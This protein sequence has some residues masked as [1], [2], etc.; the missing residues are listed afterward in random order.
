MELIKNI[1][2]IF[3]WSTWDKIFGQKNNTNSVNSVNFQTGNSYGQ[4]LSN[5]SYSIDK[6]FNFFF[7]T[8]WTCATGNAAMLASKSIN[9]S[10][11]MPSNYKG[12]HKSSLNDYVDILPTNS[13]ILSLISYPNEIDNYFDFI[14]KISIQLQLVGN[15]FIFVSK[16]TI[17]GQD[18][19]NEL[20][21][22]NPSFVQIVP[23]TVG[24]GIE[25]YVYKKKDIPADEIIQIKMPSPSNDLWGL[26]P[27][28][29]CWTDILLTYNKT[30]SDIAFQRN[31]MRPDYFVRL[32]G[33]SQ[34][35][36]QAFNSSMEAKL[37]GTENTGNVIAVNTEAEITPLNGQFKELL[38]GEPMEVKSK[39]A[40]AFKYP[41]QKLVGNDPVKANTLEAM[42]G[43][44]QDLSTYQILIENGLKKILGMYP[45]IDESSILWFEPI[46]VAD[47]TLISNDLRQ[48]FQAGIISREEIRQAK[49]AYYD[50]IGLTLTDSTTSTTANVSNVSDVSNS[51]INS[52]NSTDS[53]NSTAN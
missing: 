52:T 21:I 43:W 44:L 22:L 34:D 19:P 23:K 31:M 37:R 50:S 25:K 2:S 42:R 12:K 8:S 10:V 30:K 27:G 53:T 24:Y 26:G 18:V 15:V 3:D 1:K 14:Y 17:N 6:A 9:L 40:A 5:Q 20:V 35:Q 16:E 33:A 49:Q 4:G 48:D 28:E 11:P 41:L 29:A 46:F 51:P 36:L 45:D 7:G 38:L 39:I 47:N 13:P 32:N